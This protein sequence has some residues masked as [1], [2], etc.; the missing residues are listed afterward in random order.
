MRYVLLAPGPSM[1]QQLAD[2]VRHMP[3]GAINNAY[4]LAPDADFLAANDMAWW[5]NHPKA[6]DFAGRKFSANQIPKVERVLN[7]V[8]VCHS[9]SGVLA[10][11]CA[12][13]MG[14]TEII[15]LGFDFHG[16]HFFGSYKNG[17]SNTQEN[18][19]LVHHK[20]FDQWAKSNK[21]IK[22]VNCTPNSRLMVFPMGR[23][24]DYV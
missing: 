17:C 14:A 4:E 13:Q 24:E 11:E 22:V 21:K 12:R 20:Q 5:R 23:L 16:T 9:N 1:S 19:R 18:K 8:V 15:M 2:S 10:L 6:H 3:R 7:S